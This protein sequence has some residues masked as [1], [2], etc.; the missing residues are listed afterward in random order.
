MKLLNGSELADYIKERQA[1]QVRALRQA[2]HV[3]PKLA[4]VQTIDNPV[5]DAYVGLKKRYGADILVDVDAHKVAQNDL[6]QT[7]QQLNADESVHGII[8]QLPLEDESST[9]SAVDSVLPAK[10]VDGLGANAVLDP[11]TPMAINWLVA[12]Y[13]I[14]LV[15]K[16]VAI[17]G[18]GRLVGA[19][20]AKIWR[21]SGYDITVFD[22]DQGD[23]ATLPDYDV[24]VTATGAPGLITS[25]HIK[26]AAVVIDAG[27][28]AEHGKIIGDITD[29]VRER[30]DLT[31]TPKKGGVGPLTVTALFD[32]VIRAA[33]ATQKD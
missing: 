9:Q 19:P 6:L 24:I 4:I 8:V 2:H 29:D 13:N 12:G 14:N 16:E 5:I 18:Q 15:G 31:I 21:E 28:A 23:L 1:R 7:I 10:D 32:N 11:A 26:S 17:I 22:K 27:T 25:D 3:Y 33:E 30:D 20:L